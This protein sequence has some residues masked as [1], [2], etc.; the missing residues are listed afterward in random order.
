MGGGGG[1]TL[2]KVGF[3]IVYEIFGYNVVFIFS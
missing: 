3:L 1:G 2:G